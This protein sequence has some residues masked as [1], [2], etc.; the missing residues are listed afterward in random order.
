M[1]SI[2]RAA[3]VAL[4]L[5][6]SSLVGMALEWVVPADVLAA[7]KASVGAMVGLVT[8]LL[9]LVLGLLIY[10][11]FSVFTGQQA[12]A[13]ALGPVVAE[14]DIALERYGPEAVGGRAGLR[15]ALQRSRVRFFGDSKRGPQIHTF[16]ETKATLSGLTGYFDSLKPAADDQRN[17]LMTARGLAKQ[18]QE[19]QMKMA[20]QLAAP[21]PPYVLTVV[22][23]WASGLFL[24]DGLVATPNAVTVLAHLIGAIAIGSA[25]FLILE[26]SSPYTGVIRLSP[27]GLDSAL[28]ALGEIDPSE[29]N[30]RRNGEERAAG[31]RPAPANLA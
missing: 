4:I 21:F 8:L 27:A 20:R 15:A 29:P 2:N 6:A 24:G 18:F 25:I 17:Q 26:L 31:P 16:E 30:R 11:A 23:C 10:T 5:F 22:V 13:L 9:A 12:D 28:K 7:S 3:A 19:T 1:H 14:I